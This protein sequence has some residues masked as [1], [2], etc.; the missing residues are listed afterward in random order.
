V[1]TSAA[2]LESLPAGG[3]AALIVDDEVQLRDLLERVLSRAGYVVRAV[4]TGAE[5]LTALGEELFDLVLLDVNLPDTSGINVLTLGR[6]AQADAQF[7]VM[8]GAGSVETAV[9]AMKLAAFDYITKPIIIDEL[10]LLLERASRETQARRQAALPRPGPGQER[11]PDTH[12]LLGRSPAIRRVRELIRRVAA[13]RTPV[14]IIGETGTGKDMVARALHAASDRAA[15]PFV[16]LH[17]AALPTGYIESALFGYTKGS[18][19]WAASG[20]LGLIEQANDGTLF[21]DE[22]TSIAPEVQ[23]TLLR[24]LEDRE[25][26]RLG[27]ARPVQVNFR[28]VAASLTDLQDAVAAGLLHPNLYYRLAAFPIELPP[29]RERRA[30]IPLLAEHF[31][32]SFARENELQP[33]EIGTATMDRMMSY[34]WPGNVRELKHHV[35]RVL[36]LRGGASTAAFVE[37]LSSPKQEIAR[38]AVARASGELWTVDRLVREYTLTVLDSVGGHLGKAAG[39]LG[40]DP[41][42][43]YRRLRQYGQR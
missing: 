36:L 19:P 20:H 9:E 15:G 7:V 35:E 33:P 12:G 23:L 26:Q 8:T 37:P 16:T 32:L 27:A 40:I 11:D 22:V 21:L 42:T 13:T 24:V 29:L 38:S 18:V 30:D 6:A 5:A 41:R 39:I 25:V 31:R 34:D 3:R 14:L 2:E 28:L 4:A 1:N 17:C 10:L 43:L